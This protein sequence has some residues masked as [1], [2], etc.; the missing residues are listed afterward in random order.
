ML[1]PSRF[2]PC[3]LTQLIAMR[4][5]SV[6]I[7]RETGGLKDTVV[8][9]NCFDGSGTGFSFANYNG[10]EML[11]IINYAKKVYYE[12]RKA[13]DEIVKHGMTADYSWNTSA[14]KYEQLYDRVISLW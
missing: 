10:D 5:G 8:P 12:D 1:V 6:P 13:W 11:G 3:G 4:Y 9:Y 14:R 7:V 2:E